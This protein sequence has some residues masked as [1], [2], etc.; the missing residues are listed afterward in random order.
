MPNDFNQQVIDEFRANSGQVG[1]P[2][3]GARLLLLTTVGARSGRGHT[4]PLGYLPDGGRVLVIASAGG[5]DRNPAWFH[6]LLAHPEVTVEDGL[7]SY[8]A[9]ATV[10]PREERDR[11]FARATEA[12]PGW[13]DYQNGTTR[14]I[15]VIA[16]DNIATGPPAATSGGAFLRDIHDAFRRELARIRTEVAASGAGIGAQLRVNCLTMCQGLTGH[17]EKEDAGMLPF[18]A[19][20]YPELAPAVDRLTV[21]HHR[22]SD[23]IDELRAVLESDQVD[24]LRLGSEVERLTNEVE[25]H[26]RYEEEQ[27][28]PALDRAFP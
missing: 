8:P 3:T 15:P 4:T 5:S 27:L 22:V 28:I 12:D 20:R 25:Q 9:R 21:E 26:L 7:F 1:G 14:V 13:G 10:L 2:F 24:P 6:N 18:L 17:H 19:D 11:I 23:L 16:L